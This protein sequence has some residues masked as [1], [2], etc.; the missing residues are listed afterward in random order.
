RRAVRIEASSVSPRTILASA[1]GTSLVL[2]ATTF[3]A[4]SSDD[5]NNSKTDAA[6]DGTLIDIDARPPPTQ[7]STCRD[8]IVAYCTKSDACRGRNTPSNCTDTAELCPEYFFL[9]GSTRTI[10][11]MLQCAEAWRS[12]TCE[13]FLAGVHPACQTPGTIKAGAPCVTAPQCETLLCLG[14]TATSCGR[15]ASFYPPGAPC[16]P[17]D[18]Q[19]VCP[20]DQVCDPTT[21]KCATPKVTPVGGAGAPCGKGGPACQV[22]LVCTT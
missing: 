3:A 1:F 13:E 19:F 22:G 2:A 21:K 12:M 16:G 8:Y 14:P 4:C 20:L 9:P 17:N 10:D 15:C 18:P 7:E 11:N 6:T 5:S